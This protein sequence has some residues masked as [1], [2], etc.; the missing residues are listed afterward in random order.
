V[1][2]TKPA[3][4]QSDRQPRWRSALRGAAL[5]IRVRFRHNPGFVTAAVAGSAGLILTLILVL[6]NGFSIFDRPVD[7]ADIETDPGAELG[8]AD[9][10]PEEADDFALQ[11]VGKARLTGVRRDPFE[12]DDENSDETDRDEPIVAQAKTSQARERSLSAASRGPSFDD[13][14]LTSDDDS[15]EPRAIRDKTSVGRFDR[16]DSPTEDNA[17]DTDSIMSDDEP[18]VAAG[19]DAEEERDARPEPRTKVKSILSDADTDTDTD[20]NT[21]D[22]AARNE[23]ASDSGIR[24]DESLEDVRPARKSKS[25]PVSLPVEA[26]DDEEPLLKTSEPTPTAPSR[27]GWKNSATRSRPTGE[28]PAAATSEQSRAVETA[29]FAPPESSSPPREIP[30]PVRGVERAASS[31]LTLS[32]NVPRAVSAGQNLDLEFRVTNTGRT[33][34]R[35]VTLSV[36]LPTGLEHPLGPEVEQSIAELAPGQTHRGRLRV[37]AA[38]PGS[39]SP[40]A[41]IAIGRETLAKTTQTLRI[42]GASSSA[43]ACPPAPSRR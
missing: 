3:F 30:A 31:P 11:P 5:W 2:S 38:A 36:A 29:V 28:T 10:A 24:A 17:S 8:E 21:D 35:K 23:T 41:D 14:P 12:I 33:T 16:D 20:S 34:V 6:S 42:D 13:E 27:P 37:R 9:A 25:P 19:D 1:S 39:Y 22:D 40:R 15:T 26:T 4:F 18:L 43:Q 7:T 32:M